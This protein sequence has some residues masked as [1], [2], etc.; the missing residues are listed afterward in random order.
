MPI[1]VSSKPPAS[2]RWTADDVLAVK[3][4]SDAQIS[5]D[6]TSVA[7]VVQDRSRKGTKNLKSQIWMVDT[8]SGDTSQF[9]FGTRADLQP[10]WAPDSRSLVFRSDREEDGRF[11]I[12]HLKHDGGEARPVAEIPGSAGDVAWSSDGTRL[13]FLMEEP[14][15]EE[16]K[17]RKEEG[18][19]ILEFERNPR[20]TRIWVVN[21]DGSDLHPIST[22]AQQIWEFAWLPEDQGFAVI[23][24]DHPYE[25]SWYEAAV[26]VVP[27]TGGE[28]RTVH[29]STK[30]VAGLAP[31][32]DGQ[33][34]ACISATWSDRNV[35]GGDV[36]LVPVAGGDARCLTEGYPGSFG[37]VHWR[38]ERTLIAVGYQE[39]DAAV[40]LLGLDHP[41]QQMWSAPAALSSRAWARASFTANS[42]QMAV[43]REAPTA[44]PNVWTTHLPH[45]HGDILWTPRTAMNRQLEELIQPEVETLHWTSPDG[46]PIQGLLLKPHGYQ[47]GRRYPLVTVVHGGPTSLYH[48][49]YPSLSWFPILVSRGMA[50]LLPN[51]RG[52]TGWGTAF[53]E[54]NLGD[55]G[56]ADLQ[57]ILAGVDYLVER[58]IADPERLGIAGWSYGGFMTA[59]AV[60][61]TDR[62]RAAMMGAG[63]A[64]WRSFH[65]VSNLPTWDRRYYE[66]DP[67]ELGGPFDR[68]SPVMHIRNV[69]TP[70]LILHGEQDAYVPVGQGYEFFRALRDHGV[71]AELVV[72]PREGHG[73]L[74][75][76]HAHD[77]L[78]RTVDWFEKRLHVTSDA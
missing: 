43:I 42:A 25:W 76:P 52:S 44:P 39:G 60:T 65:G 50:V 63:I 16:I 64:D 66:A 8:R 56:G 13:A 70:T 68:F 20:Y 18:G 26:G 28:A 40:I 54:A 55:M 37:T 78:T 34:I 7:Y 77:M 58:G 11:G 47:E 31:S 1:E 36:W 35:V 9:T 19:E 48:H 38:D 61:Q 75:T 21:L 12:Y 30:Q 57:D 59:W 14:E 27:A 49:S 46:T 45:S 17:Q 33:T 29:R 51:P 15:T 10:R 3:L 32:P 62:F 73:I 53:A 69:R 2:R 5:P 6:G 24:S 74:E 22:D 72:Y 4:P 67:Y 71:E 23:Y 41:P